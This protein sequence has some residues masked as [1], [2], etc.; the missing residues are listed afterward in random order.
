MI[1]VFKR[2]RDLIRPTSSTEAGA[3]VLTIDLAI[4]GMGL[5]FFGACMAARG[6][7]L[8]HLF[9]GFKVAGA[10]LCAFVLSLAPLFAI[11]RFFEV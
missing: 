9:S 6:D 11:R 7:L 10:F 3:Q 2:I 5:W 8:W 4:A 1:T